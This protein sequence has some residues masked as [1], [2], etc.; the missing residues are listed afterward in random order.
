[1]VVCYRIILCFL[2]LEYLGRGGIEKSFFI[3]HLSL[4]KLLSFTCHLPGNT[5]DS[6]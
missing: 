5:L 2:I 3:N 4:H 1:M 6:T